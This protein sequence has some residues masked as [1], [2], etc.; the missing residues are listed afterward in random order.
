MDFLDGLLNF[1]GN[2]GSE[3]AQLILQLFQIIVTI[4]QFLWQVLGIVFNFFLKIVQ[5]VGKFF[6]HIWDKFFKGIFTDV[7]K[8]IVKFGQW[9]KGIFGPVVKFLRTASRFIDRIYNHYIRPILRWIR[10]ARVFLQLLKALHIKWA[11]KLDSILGKVQT[12]IQRAFLTVKQYLNVVIDLLNILADPSNLLRRPTTLLSLR[13]IWH[14]FIRQY[15]GLPPGFF[16]PSPSKLAPPGLG[17]LPF[18]FDPRDPLQNTPPSYYLAFDGGVPS[19]DFLVEGETIADDSIDSVAPADFYNS[20]LYPGPVC[21][22]IPG[23]RD[24]LVSL[25]QGALRNA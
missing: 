3:I 19:F 2:F 5:D 8:G 1:L 11:A 10:I 7:L 13:R 9:L 23:C 12:D 25:A 16:V 18:N 22:D 6:T 21:D 24:Q 4:F 15:T 20:D 14:A 17:L